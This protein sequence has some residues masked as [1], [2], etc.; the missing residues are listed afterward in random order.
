V[1]GKEYRKRI[2]PQSDT[3]HPQYSIFPELTSA[4]AEGALEIDVQFHF[5]QTVQ[6]SCD[7]MLA[8]SC[9]V[10]RGFSHKPRPEG[11][12][13]NIRDEAAPQAIR[14]FATKQ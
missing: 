12:S 3:G 8:V 11:Y 6:I 7:A 2:T 4:V 13:T 9:T 14:G 10:Q 5:G 1:G